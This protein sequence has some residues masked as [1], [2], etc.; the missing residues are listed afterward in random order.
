M[1]RNDGLERTSDVFLLSSQPKKER[2]QPLG[3][4]APDGTKGR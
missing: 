2:R 1:R 4:T 3:T